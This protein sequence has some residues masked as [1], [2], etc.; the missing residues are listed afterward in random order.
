MQFLIWRSIPFLLNMAPTGHDMLQCH[1]MWFKE[2]KTDSGLNE[3][4]LLFKI[5][6]KKQ[7][8]DTMWVMQHMPGL[9]V[10]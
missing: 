3:Y 6:K 2:K 10:K 7:H 8:K 4:K 1:I 5:K 9:L